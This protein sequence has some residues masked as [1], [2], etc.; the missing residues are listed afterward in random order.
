MSFVMLLQCGLRPV[1]KPVIALLSR[2]VD[3]SGI[4]L[5]LMAFF[6]RDFCPNPQDQL[7]HR[8]LRGHSRRDPRHL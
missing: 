8:L 1:I 4:G 5:T 6:S 7:E 2:M 3:A